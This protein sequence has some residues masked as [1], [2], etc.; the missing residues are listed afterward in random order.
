MAKRSKSLRKQILKLIKQYSRVTWPEKKFIPGQTPVSVS[1]RVF[2]FD[3]VTHLTDATLDFWLTT[4]RFAAQFE[5][6]F[7]KLL[8]AKYAILCNSGSSANLLA[9]SCLTSQKLGK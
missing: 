1:G 3:D 6:D 7:A 5:Q 8:K 2:D 4:G 9:V